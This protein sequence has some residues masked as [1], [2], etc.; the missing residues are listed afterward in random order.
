MVHMCPD[1][2]ILS[3]YFDGELPSPWKEKMET[4]LGSCPKC[5]AQL[6][7]F[8]RCSTVLKGA[9]EPEIG[10]ME[11][12]KDRIWENLT[13]LDIEKWRPNRERNLWYRR[14]S[15]PF[16]A[17]AAAVAILFIAFILTLTRQWGSVPPQQDTMTTTGITDMQ[18]IVP[19]SNMHDVLQYLGNQDSTDIVI[20]R[21]PESKSFPSA[22]EPTILKAADYSRRS[23]SR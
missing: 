21:L 3:V 18:G 14:V 12:A 4:H 17:A 15:I 19:V 8:R 6:E 5:R 23:G 7:Q 2:H 13:R 20:I 22:G 10:R 16:P 9:V 1:Y 11:S